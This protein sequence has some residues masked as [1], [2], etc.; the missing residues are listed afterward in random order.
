MMA[1]LLTGVNRAYPYAKGQL[2]YIR[3]SKLEIQNGIS[4]FPQNNFW[5]NVC[6]RFIS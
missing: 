4:V 1:A 3:A 5:K 6:F 2:V